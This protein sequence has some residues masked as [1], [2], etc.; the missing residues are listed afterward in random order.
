MTEPGPT[1]AKVG[2]STCAAENAWTTAGERVIVTGVNHVLVLSFLLAVTVISL[3]PGPDMLYVLANGVSHGRRAG[4]LA[5]LGM[6]TGLA[7][8]TVAAS[9]GLSALLLAAPVVFHALRVLGALYLGYL[10][11]MALRSSRRAEEDM[12]APTPGRRSLRRVY[13]M[14]VLT[15]LANPKVILFYLAFFPQFVMPADPLPVPAQF[16]LLGVLF[17]AVGLLVDASVGLAAGHLAALFRRRP[18]VRRWLDRLCAAVFGGL[19]VRLV[20]DQ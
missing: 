2:G 9:L 13:L 7:V 6:S 18:S 20:L 15:N 11:I 5:A 1:E 14:G 10:A 16:L 8:H 4:V 19:A 3:V 12:A 17:I